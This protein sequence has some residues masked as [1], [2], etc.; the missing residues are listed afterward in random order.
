MILLELSNEINKMEVWNNV[1][2]CKTNVRLIY[3]C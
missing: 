3:V 1:L 2:K